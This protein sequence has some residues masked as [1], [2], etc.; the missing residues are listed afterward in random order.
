MSAFAN[1]ANSQIEAVCIDGRRLDSLTTWSWRNLVSKCAWSD[2]SVEV[3]EA[4][5]CGAK[6]DRLLSQSIFGQKGKLTPVSER[7][8]K[9]FTDVLKEHDALLSQGLG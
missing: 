7:Y 8:V 1:W 4:K 9:A 5:Q 6:S 2:V 3:P